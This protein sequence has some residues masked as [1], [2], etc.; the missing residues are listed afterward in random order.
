[1]QENFGDFMEANGVIID[2]TC[3]FSAPAIVGI[4]LGYRVG[5]I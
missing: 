4:I 2:F 5:A 3:N 1:V